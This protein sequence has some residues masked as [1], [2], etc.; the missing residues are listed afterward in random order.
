MKRGVI[1]F[2]LI[3]LI[4]NVYAIGISPATKELNF[5]PNLKENFRIEVVNNANYDIEATLYLGGDLAQYA[6]L[7]KESILIKKGQ[8]AV[9]FYTIKLPENLVIPGL[10][11][12][13]IGAKEN[14][15]SYVEGTGISARTSVESIL[16]IFVPYP[17]KYAEMSFNVNNV[18]INDPIIFNI[19]LTNLGKEQIQKAKATIDIY[20]SN[21]KITS[22]NTNE[23]SIDSESAG[24]LTATYAD[25]SKPGIFLAK[26]LVDYDGILINDSREFRIG[27][28][29][30][31]IVNHTKYFQQDKINPFDIEIASKWNS[32]ID[33]IYAEIEIYQDNK[34]IT[35]AFKTPSTD[36][37]PW[38]KKTLT[39]YWDTTGLLPAAY[40][41]KITLSYMNLTTQK[42]VDI[43]IIK[44]FEFNKT[45][46]LTILVIA[47]ALLDILW[48]IF[49]KKK[50]GKK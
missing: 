45:L 41:A 11:L 9:A 17:G 39:S 40:Q 15:P 43:S 6:V 4:S 28:L 38:E 46:L 42:I 29:S 27:I 33:N 31:D 25:T 21:L 37:N 47:I 16:K 49:R 32:R 34:K 1:I 48:M 12:L 13:K 18:N 36:L 2:I 5:Q 24:I 35:Q 14:L 23:I 8:S 7:S 44:K 20:E 22:L 26:A 50:D 3:A 30:V 19:L 10:H